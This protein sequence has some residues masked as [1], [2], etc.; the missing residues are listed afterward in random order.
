[1]V[2][3]PVELLTRL[4]GEVHGVRGGVVLGPDGTVLAQIWP[5]APGGPARV[6]GLCAGLL[7]HL[8]RLAAEAELGRPRRLSLRGERGQLV[9]GRSR[10][11]L[12]V[13]I[14]A[15]PETLGG[16]L[17]RHLEDLLASL[18][19]AGEAVGGTAPPDGQA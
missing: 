3:D 9:I 4:G 17:R 12:T 13:A 1:M 15:G 10:G 8:E 2:A 5:E 7:D 11:G 6:V 18:E 19:P 16:Q 14:A